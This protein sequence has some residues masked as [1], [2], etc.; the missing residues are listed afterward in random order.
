[1]MTEESDT[2]FLT[3]HS[4]LL[5]DDD[6]SFDVSTLQSEGKLDVLS[7]TEPASPPLLCSTPIPRE[8]GLDYDELI[9]NFENLKSECLQPE[10]SDD[11]VEEKKKC[12]SVLLSHLKLFSTMPKDLC[13]EL[14][15]KLRNLE[16]KYK[17]KNYRRK[18]NN[19]VKSKEKCQSLISESKDDLENPSTSAKVE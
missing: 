18:Y 8:D 10:N 15:R 16:M 14:Q 11:T 2:A 5:S 6:E 12:C 13:N 3:A 19:F 4:M 7:L 9:K 1:M 17:L